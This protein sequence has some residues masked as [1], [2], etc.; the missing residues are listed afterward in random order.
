[1]NYSLDE[2]T[3]L[4]NKQIEI[5]KNAHE[6]AEMA[7]SLGWPEDC[8]AIQSAK[9]EHKNA[10]LIYNV[11]KE[12]YDNLLVEIENSKWAEKE[13]EYPAATAIWRYMTDLGWSDYD[14][15]EKLMAQWQNANKS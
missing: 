2:L 6:L 4:M 3:N 10:S 1:M 5:K 11:Y 8:Q 13:A 12:R 15:L 14:T 7:R 9:V